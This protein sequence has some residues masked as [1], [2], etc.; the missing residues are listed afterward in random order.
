MGA[1]TAVS[2]SITVC[3]GAVEAAD[4][5]VSVVFVRA[6]QA[7]ST[8]VARGSKSSA[9]G[10]ALARRRAVPRFAVDNVTHGILAVDIVDLFV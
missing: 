9:R 5:T 8:G 10:L 3:P 1:R 7:A 6:V 2:P 4:A